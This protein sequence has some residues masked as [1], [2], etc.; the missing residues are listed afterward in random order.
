MV[1]RA[2]QL[3]RLRKNKC[4][5]CGVKMPKDTYEYYPTLCRRCAKKEMRKKR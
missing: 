5:E 2:T 1:T 3:R 4:V